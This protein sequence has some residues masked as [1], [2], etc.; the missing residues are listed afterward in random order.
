MSMP[1]QIAGYEDYVALT[2]HDLEEVLDA[3]DH[4]DELF[5]QHEQDM[6]EEMIDD[7]Q[8]YDSEMGRENV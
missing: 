8:E 3:I 6:L 1:I 7:N 5:G 4:E 2:G